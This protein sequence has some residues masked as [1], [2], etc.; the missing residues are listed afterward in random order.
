MSEYTLSSL[1]EELAPLVMQK[2]VWPQIASLM[3]LIEAEELWAEEG[4]SSFSAWVSSFAA[5]CDVS[6]SYLWKALKAGRVYTDYQARV[7][8]DTPDMED[9]DISADALV[10]ADKIAYGNAE[11]ADSII[12]KAMNGEISVSDMN[13][14]WHE[15]R[16]RKAKAEENGSAYEAYMPF[17]NEYEIP[18][19]DDNELRFQAKKVL[20]NAKWLERIIAEFPSQTLSRGGVEKPKAKL[21]SGVKI[22]DMKLPE[23]VIENYTVKE[24]GDVKVHMIGIGEDVNAAAAQ[25]A[26]ICWV[27]SRERVNRPHN[28]GGL[29]LRERED[30]EGYVIDVDA[31]PVPLN[32][33]RKQEAIHA[34]LLR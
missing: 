14:A 10:L 27:L 29:L 22:G 24:E 19:V 8:E 21:V 18:T 17:G 5:E 20:R 7:G 4:H 1:K 3:M 6:E 34:A 26:D 33:H 15:V 30:R 32:P 25:Y 16:E 23:M 28:W 2:A 11:I 31:D 12:Q 9:I 13:S